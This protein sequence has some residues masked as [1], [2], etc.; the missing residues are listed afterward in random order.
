[1]LPLALGTLLAVA[2]LAFVLYPLLFDV[3]TSAARA[4]R[5]PRAAQGGDEDAVAALREIEFDRA[6]GKLSD[7]DY[8]ELK[9]RY[10]ARAL[11]AMRA[12]GGAGESADAQDVVE[13]TVLAYR[14]RL[15]SCARCG[16]RPEPDAV[17]CSN[18]GTYL[19]EK[20]AGCGRIVEEAGAAFC[21]GCG[22]QLAA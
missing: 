10:T 22:R 5:V 4:P 12:V 9:A 8:A 21:S 20:C 16:P 19:D 18:C 3:R 2:A 1:M 15:R 13:A 11:E 6:T 17:Y 7:T 14:A